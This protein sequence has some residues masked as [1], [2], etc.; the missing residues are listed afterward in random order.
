MDR[1]E[2]L[3]TTFVRHTDQDISEMREWR[4]HSQKQWGEIAQKLGTF[5]EDIVAPNIPRIAKDVFAFGG[6]DEELFSG[7]RL[8]LRH[9]M[10]AA[11]MREFD[12]IY[13]TRRGWIV[14]ESKSDPKL[15]DVDSFR[16]LLAEVGEYFPQYAALV[17]RPIFASLYVPE[18]VAKYCTRH[19]IY[20]LGMGPETM[21]L[22][23]LSELPS[24]RTAS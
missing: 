22:L 4:I 16:E 3:I 2:A 23:N 11:K 10:D 6:V 20:A 15:R 5:V 24:A 9:P 21:Q 1:L 14:V 18:H 8:R 17:L 19:N 13:A 7:P 12:Y